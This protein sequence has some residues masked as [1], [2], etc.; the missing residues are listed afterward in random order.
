MGGFQV[1]VQRGQKH[2]FTYQEE[3]DDVDVYPASCNRL[4][5]SNRN[6]NKEQF[7]SPTCTGD[8]QI[9]Q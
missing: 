5:L 6:G 8:V 2:I 4:I 7:H 1:F 9:I 3:E